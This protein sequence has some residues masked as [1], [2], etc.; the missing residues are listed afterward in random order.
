MAK[1]WDLNCLNTSGPSLVSERHSWFL[2]YSKDSGVSFYSNISSI[3]SS[4]NN[5][6]QLQSTKISPV[7]KVL[8]QSVCSA[9]GQ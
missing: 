6:H 9:F 4:N 1:R 5:C 2:T 8:R 3:T 7:A